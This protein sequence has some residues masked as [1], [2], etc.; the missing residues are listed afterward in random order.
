MPEIYVQPTPRQGANFFD[1][2][3]APASQGAE[4][5]N[6][7]G[8]MESG[9]NYQ[10]VGPDAGKGRGHAIGKYQVLPANVGP[11]TKEAI[12]VE[13]TPE[14]FAA[15]PA[16]QDA[17]FQHKFVG[18]YLP[19]YGPEGAARA[20]FAGEEGM[21]HPARTDVNGTSVAGYGQ[22]A[23]LAMS[24][25]TGNFFDQ[26]DGGQPEVIPSVSDRFSPV[27]AQPENPALQSALQDR[28]ASM[29]QGAAQPP[30]AQMATDFDNVVPAA[31][32]GTTPN[33]DAYKG[34]LVSSEVFQNDAGEIEYRDPTTGK[35]VPTDTKTQVAIRD[36]Q[37]GVVKIFSRSE[38]TNES[39][40]V[41]VSRVLSSGMAAGAP[42]A[43]PG[44]AAPMARSIQPR[45]SDVMATAKPFYKAFKDEAGKIYLSA[46]TRQDMALRIR[47]ALDNANFI[48]ELAK[49][50]YSATKILEKDKPISLDELQQVKRVIGKSFNSPEKNVR[51]AA[52][53]ASAEI[54]R[55]IA[56]VSPN[57]AKS[58]KTGD[59]IYSTA[60]SVQ[61][62]QR[63]SEIAGLRA[64][65]SGYGG[66]S[67]NSMR[68][69]LKP[70]VTKAIEGRVTG[71]QPAEIQAMRDIVEGTTATNTLRGIGQFSP[72]KGIMQT[73][74]GLTAIG[75]GA[76][77]A[78]PAGAVV[79]AAIPA[80]GA[81]SNK[82][83]TILT[84]K[85]IERLQTL[86]AKRS[87]AYAEA[88]KRSVDRY[89]QAQAAF[90]SK[91]APNTLA[92][93]L[94]ASRALSAGLTRDGIQVSSGDLLRSIQGP[95]NAAAD[96][97]EPKPVGIG[98]Q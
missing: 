75:G 13:L 67:V 25:R 3:D 80:L 19:K 55:I 98:H 23:S 9:G 96:D 89:E 52:G 77:V 4:A 49:P 6:T 29:T 50:V 17:V 24:A 88:V 93:Y 86:V 26:F 66:N 69:V 64:G 76:V 61:D 46:E 57:A 71:F 42:T 72:T 15:S 20:W 78:G 59:Q 28:A 87:P 35:V 18:Q 45:A 11:W 83:A 27:T 14:Q 65:S 33:V 63:K 79:A 92:G 74:G 2:F 8:G 12:G 36:P 38:D 44:I 31:T 43:R 51:D 54:G 37:D 68:Q 5:A 81:A 82:L 7:I 95:I 41:G 84:G 34:R 53:V 56:E 73:G 85:Q 91:P 58:L 94:S 1:Q 62:L 39:P 47:D 97:E 60:R 21:N 32:Q 22:R 16:V 30:A 40:V 48:E 10:A 90:A 70:I